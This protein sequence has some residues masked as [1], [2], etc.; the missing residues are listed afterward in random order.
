MS[1]AMIASFVC[2]ALV[3][4]LN[5][6][7]SVVYLTR[8]E[9]MPYHREAIGKPWGEL[10]PAVRT[11]ILALMRGGGVSVFTIGVYMGLILLFPFREGRSWAIYSLPVLGIASGVALLSVVTFVKKRT[12]AHPPIAASIVVIALC[13]AGLIFSLF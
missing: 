7:F 1:H 5:F 6:G 10:D 9:F 4:V 13:A 3:I 11:I 12:S 2:Y 8:S